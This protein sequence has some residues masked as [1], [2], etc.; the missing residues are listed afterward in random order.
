MHK[1]IHLTRGWQH[2]WHLSLFEKVLIVN[3]MMLIGEASAGL[4]ITSY[5]R[6]IH[7]Y[8]IDTLF[9]IFATLA[10]ICI[11]IFLLRASF[12]PLFNLLAAIREISAGKTQ[13]RANISE[14][15]WEIG[16]LAQAFNGML[17][18]LETARREQTMAILQAQE[19]ERRRIGMELHDEAGQNL[20]AL[21]IHTEVLQQKFQHLA[22]TGITKHGCQQVSQEVQQLIQLTQVTLENI[23]VLAQQLRPSVLDDL[24]LRAAFRW[25]AEDSGQRLHLTVHLT[26]QDDIN[27]LDYLPPTF[28]TA[29]FRI[30][31]ESLTNVARHAHAEYVTMKITC[32]SQQ[33]TLQVS[34]NG[35]GY[36]PISHKSG[37][38][39]LGMR[40]RAT[41]LGG[42]LTI[43][44]SAGN[45][46]TVCVLLPLP[47][48]IEPSEGNN[49]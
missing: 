7:H 14:T 13:T 42:T 28:E 16:E 39:I 22:E 38:G 35:Q 3:S 25:L 48:A 11:N 37:S 4:W 12:R 31:Q 34:D 29:I 46:T 24:G 2:D 1:R 43:S 19:Q 8:L 32:Q 10:T 45:G 6:E 26:L 30:A 33:L 23:R 44:S 49:Q 21:L 18:R 15:S 36:D 41:T 40:E 20:T 9:I 5:Q 47:P 27:R 17:D